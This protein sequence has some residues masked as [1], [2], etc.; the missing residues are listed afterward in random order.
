MKV[1]RE[2]QK[3]LDLPN[4]PIECTAVRVP[5]LRAH[6]ESITIETKQR[7]CIESVQKILRNALGVKLA[8]DPSRNMYPM[9]SNVNGQND[10]QV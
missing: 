3:I 8:D 9:P 7:F 4:L 2:L 5:I 6:S 1:T 10:V